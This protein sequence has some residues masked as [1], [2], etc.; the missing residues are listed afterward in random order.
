MLLHLQAS[1]LT[2]SIMQYCF[3][4]MQN[5]LLCYKYNEI[6]VFAM[7]IIVLRGLEYFVLQQVSIDIAFSDHGAF[8]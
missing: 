8:Q 4:I 6:F 2:T 3:F 1:Y 5:S 7:K